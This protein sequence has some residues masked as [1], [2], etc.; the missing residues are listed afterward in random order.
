[1][2]HHRKAQSIEKVKKKEE[3]SEQIIIYGD[4]KGGNNVGR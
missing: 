3:D 4:G 1:M 2:L